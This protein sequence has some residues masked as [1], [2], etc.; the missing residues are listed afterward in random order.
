MMVVALGRLG[1]REFDIRSD[2]DLL[3]IIPDDE[4]KRHR[5]WIRV[6]E[7]LLDVLSSYSGAGPTLSIDTRLRPNGRE[8]M[9]VQT[10]S[11]YVEYFSAKAEAW[12]GIAYMK[13]RAV[14]GDTDRATKFL[15]ELQQVDWRRYGQSG[16]SRQELRQMR[17]RLE[18]EQGTIAP[19]KAEQGGYYDADFIL[20]YLRLRGAGMFFKS[21]NTPERIDVVEKMGHLER[22][23][24]E[25]L[26]EAATHFR[27]LDHAIRLVT[28]HAEGKLPAS[29]E[30][31]ETIA[32]LVSRW[33]GT[34]AKAETLETDLQAL[35]DKMHRLFERVFAE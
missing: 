3:F 5:F 28:G 6:V 9:L 14:A 4:A 29:K 34:R 19:L 25:F 35:Q 23:D 16:R 13:A 7:R 1:M 11:K 32:A 26:L 10:E 21:L 12:E 27:A 17:I 15:V 33:T 22:V 24:A 18:K 2:A 31:R 20:M 30:Q 8:G